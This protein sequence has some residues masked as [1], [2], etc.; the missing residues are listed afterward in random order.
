MLGIDTLGNYW[1]LSGIFSDCKGTIC[2]GAD[3]SLSL[4]RQN[5]LLSS[6]DL[7]TLFP[8]ALPRSRTSSSLSENALPILPFLM[9]SSP[10]NLLPNQIT[11]LLL[12][13]LLMTA[14]RSLSLSPVPRRC[15]PPLLPCSPHKENTFDWG[16]LVTWLM[17]PE[18]GEV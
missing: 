3:N 1:D 16:I 15:Y 12:F 5:P 6:P 17:P 14:Q 4:S 9:S 8:S 7:R 11:Q 10:L 18:K 13:L 2:V